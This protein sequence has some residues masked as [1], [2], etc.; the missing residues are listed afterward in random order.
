MQRYVTPYGPLYA[1]SDDEA[2][3]RIDT[4]GILHCMP[5]PGAFA[6]LV[7]PGPEG[8]DYAVQLKV[9][10]VVEYMDADS[11]VRRL[12]DRFA[13]ELLERAPEGWQVLGEA[14]D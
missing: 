1:L 14:A 12:L 6:T 11:D 4:A 8:D 9:D 7:A 5:W 13:A 3:E 2:V 10:G